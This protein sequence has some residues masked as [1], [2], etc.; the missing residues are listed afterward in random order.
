MALPQFW[1]KPIAQLDKRSAKQFIRI[2]ERIRA[3]EVRVIDDKG[4]QLGIMPPFDALK[5]ARERG[6]DLVEVSPTAVPPVCRIQDYGKFL[7]EKDKSE[8]AARKKQKVIVVKEVKFS[9]TVDEHDYQTKK[10]QAVRFLTEG[11]KVKASLRFKGRQMAHRELGY[12]I[13]NRLIQDIGDA[14]IVE[15]M[16]RMEGTTLHA[17]LAPGKKDVPKKPVA[18][19]PAAPAAPPA[20]TSA[21]S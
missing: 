13:I 4:E 20:Q 7:Y 17:I 12:A 15:F 11:D 21:Q 16:P 5:I 10:N 8:R 19:K 3:R 2:N 9:V 1:R 18:P 6:L 14:G